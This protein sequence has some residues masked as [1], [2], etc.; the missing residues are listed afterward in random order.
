MDPVAVLAGLPALGGELP[1]TYLVGLPP[2]DLEEGIG[3][4][5]TAAAR[6]ARGRPSR[7]PARPTSW[8]LVRAARRGRV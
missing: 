2:G 1:P 6:G 4:S 7:E 3:L 5:P 8:S